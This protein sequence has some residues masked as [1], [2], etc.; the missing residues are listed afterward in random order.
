MVDVFIAYGSNLQLNCPKKKK[1]KK[2]QKQKKN[3]FN[4]KKG[5]KTFKQS[6]QRL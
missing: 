4:N 1:P 2:K 3:N 6:S 5:N